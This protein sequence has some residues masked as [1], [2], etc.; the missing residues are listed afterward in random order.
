MFF[1]LDQVTSSRVTRYTIFLR[2]LSVQNGMDLVRSDMSVLD[3]VYFISFGFFQTFCDTACEI[4]SIS[5]S[6]MIKVCVQLN[7]GHVVYLTCGGVSRV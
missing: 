6:H 2:L 7:N 3:I 4:V 5:T 1:C